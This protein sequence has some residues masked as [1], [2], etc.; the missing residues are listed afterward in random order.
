MAAWAMCVSSCRSADLRVDT[1]SATLACYAYLLALSLARSSAVHVFRR[2]N[3]RLHATLRGHCY[4]GHRTTAGLHG[5]L[6]LKL[7]CMQDSGEHVRA[8]VDHM[9]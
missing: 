2:R 9:I 8:R 6:P 1:P 4:D 3:R 5:R 7:A